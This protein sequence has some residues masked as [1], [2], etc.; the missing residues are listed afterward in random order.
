MRRAGE[1]AMSAEETLYSAI[2][3]DPADAIAWSAL[4]DCFEEKGE[5]DRAEL[6]RLREWLR[7][8]PRDDPQRGERESRMQGLLASGALPPVPTRSVPIGKDVTLELNLIPP[9]SFWMGRPRKEAPDHYTNETPEHHVS[10]TRG[11]YLGV[12][13]VTTRQQAA[14]VGRPWDRRARKK[15]DLPVIG[16]SWEECQGWCEELVKKT[17]LPFRLA[18]EAEWEYGCR[19]GT[20]TEHHS[21]NGREALDQVAWYSSGG[22]TAPRVRPSRRNT[23]QPVARKIPNAWGLYDMHG[24]AWEWCADGQRAYTDEAVTDPFGKRANNR[25]IRGGSFRSVSWRCW[26]AC[27]WAYAL[28]ARYDDLGCRLAMDLE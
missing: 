23:V 6:V 21:G 15:A 10:L 18:S 17:G 3:A 9:G 26:S 27:R 11:F 14:L 16:V 13:H 28:T 5:T 1:K 7:L 22:G 4:A 24:N 25:V 20:T 2:A 19:A 12:H 8:A